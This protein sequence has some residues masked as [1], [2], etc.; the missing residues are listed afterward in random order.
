MVTV[1]ANG[2]SVRSPIASTDTLTVDETHDP[3]DSYSSVRLVFHHSSRLLLATYSHPSTS[4]FSLRYQSASTL[5]V[6]TKSYIRLSNHVGPLLC[7]EGGIGGILSRSVVMLVSTMV[8]GTAVGDRKLLD[9]LP[10]A[11]SGRSVLAPALATRDSGSSGSKSKRHLDLGTTS[12]I[13]VDIKNTPKQT[14][15]DASRTTNIKDNLSTSF[16]DPLTAAQTFVQLPEL[17]W[18]APDT[19]QI[20]FRQ[21]PRCPD[22]AREHSCGLPNCLEVISST[23]SN[24]PRPQPRLRCRSQCP[25]PDNLTNAALCPSPNHPPSLRV[26]HMTTRNNHQSLSL[27]VPTAFFR[28]LPLK[29]QLQGQ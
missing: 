26:R 10:Q 20:S 9:H 4:P 17:E 2:V 29:R 3:T 6:P 24:V 8:S 1:P 7:A 5:E 23:S 27:C 16:H 21:T 18:S 14:P 25:Y 11:C 12:R 15:I 28:P 19:H 22:L 13:F